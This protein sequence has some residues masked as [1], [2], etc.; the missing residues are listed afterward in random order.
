MYAQCHSL[1]KSRKKRRRIQKEKKNAL[2]LHALSKHL[3]HLLTPPWILRN[4]IPLRKESSHQLPLVRTSKAIVEMPCFMNQNPPERKK[5]AQ[6]QCSFSL[7]Q[8]APLAVDRKIITRKKRKERK[9]ECGTWLTGSWYNN[10]RKSNLRRK[11][12]ERKENHQKTKQIAGCLSVGD[13][14]YLYCWYH[15]SVSVSNMMSHEPCSVFPVYWD[16]SAYPSQCMLFVESL[17]RVP[18]S[19]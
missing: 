15:P 3:H 12:E 19:K 16:C 13:R 18:L 5:K 11:C 7:F 9:K 1:P 10:D 8:E 4:G 17:K 2:S 6:S 14:A